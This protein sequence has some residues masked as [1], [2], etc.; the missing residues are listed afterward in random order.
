METK[1]RLFA[2]YSNNTCVEF[3]IIR[4]YAN[5]L[6]GRDV[7]CLGDEMTVYMLMRAK[8]IGSKLATCLYMVQIGYIL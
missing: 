5:Q 6:K 1:R 7:G 8:L 2:E 4:P 3:G